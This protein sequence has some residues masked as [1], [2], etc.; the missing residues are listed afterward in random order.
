[1]TPQHFGI[2]LKELWEIDGTKHQPGLVVHGA[3]WPLSES[4]ASGGS[5]LYHFEDRL[6]TLGLIADL[7]YTNP[8]LS[9]F[10]ELQRYKTHPSIKQFLKGGKRIGYG[11]R[12]ITKGGINSLPKMSM[13]GAL[14]IGCD[15]GTLN[16]SKIKGTHTV[17]YTHL[18]LPTILLV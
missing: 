18:T 15:A 8:H 3:G 2:G 14:L 17:S 1:M 6:V 9:P 5:F 16:F 13:P 7:S 11:A 12:T 4:K 10:D